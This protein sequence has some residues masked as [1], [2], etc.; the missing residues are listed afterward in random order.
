MSGFEQ[1]S[2]STLLII[3][4]NLLCGLDAVAAS[5]RDG[6]FEVV[7]ERGAAPP[8]QLGKRRSL[9]WLLSTRSWPPV[10]VPGSPVRRYPERM[11]RPDIELSEDAAAFVEQHP[12]EV[13]RLAGRNRR[14][15]DPATLAPEELE[16][17]RVRFRTYIR[18]RRDLAA[19]PDVHAAGEA[20][21]AQF[22]RAS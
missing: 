20:W 10:T 15:V 22:T 5:L 11:R 12:E 2:T 14:Q 21:L 13:A 1:A 7:G 3:R 4:G 6:T 9:C 18:E 16:R 19:S 17:R 8:S